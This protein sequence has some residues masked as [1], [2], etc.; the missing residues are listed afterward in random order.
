MIKLMFA[1]VAALVLFQDPKPVRNPWAGFPDGSFAVIESVTTNDG[2]TTTEKQ[3]FTVQIEKDGG[4]THLVSKEEKDPSIFFE[5]RHHTPGNAPDKSWGTTSKPK[6][7]ELTLG[8]KK[9]ACEITDYV[10]RD[11]GRRVEVRARV[12]R[13]RD[14]KVP[15]REIKRDG[16]DIALDTD[17]VRFEMTSKTAEG[18]QKFTFAIVDPAAKITVGGKELPCQLEEGAAEESM[19]GQ[20]LKAT[21]RR[22]LTDAIPGRVARQEIRGEANG[23]KMERTETVLSWSTK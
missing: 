8:G 7:A 2:K 5:V 17:V 1:A 18:S 12:W 6:P 11:E 19:G 10:H 14:L 3:R 23:K 13:T 15:Y 4:V 16:A 21:V 9:L 20:T 22:W